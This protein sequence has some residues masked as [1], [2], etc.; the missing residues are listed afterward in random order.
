M[1]Y[2]VSLIDLTGSLPFTVEES[3]EKNKVMQVLDGD[4]YISNLKDF[5]EKLEKA[6]GEK[7]FILQSDMIGD[8]FF[9]RILLKR[10]GMIE[11]SNNFPCIVIGHF[12]KKDRAKKFNLALKKVLLDILS[13]SK[14]AKSIIK[15]IELGEDKEEIDI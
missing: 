6:F 10:N 9:Y 2:Y 11:I 1:T 4:R 3:S 12:I 7:L 5:L 14:T 8:R 15:N 13:P